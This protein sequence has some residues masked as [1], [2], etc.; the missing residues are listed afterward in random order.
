VCVCVCVRVC[1]CVCVQRSGACLNTADPIGISLYSYLHSSFLPLPPPPNDTTTAHGHLALLAGQI[2]LDPATMALVQSPPPPPSP[3]S[4]PDSTDVEGGQQQEQQQEQEQQLELEAYQALHNCAAVLA[5]LRSSLRAAVMVVVYVNVGVVSSSSSSSSSSFSFSSEAVVEGWRRVCGANA[6]YGQRQRQQQE[7]EAWGG[8]G[9]SG[10]ESE[11][12]EDE[13]EEEEVPALVAHCP[14]LVVGVPGLPRGA[15]VEFEV[16]AL[17][18]VLVGALRPET[19]AWTVAAAAADD[20]D[21]Q[22]V[23]GGLGWLGDR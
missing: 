16:M 22:E 6:S 13:G 4:S 18:R 10:S 20:D 15:L 23:R 12:E 9:A 17:S 19:A 11:E 1:V 3:S 21:G 8:G 5:A 7:A 14:F 2:G